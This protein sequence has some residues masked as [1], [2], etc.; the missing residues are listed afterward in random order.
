M[1]MRIY[2]RNQGGWLAAV[3]LLLMGL[4]A[5]DR[6]NSSVSPKPN[7]KPPVTQP[8]GIDP[9]ADCLVS[10]DSVCGDREVCLKPCRK[11][12]HQGLYAYGPAACIAECGSS[13]GENVTCL[14]PCFSACGGAPPPSVAADA[15]HT[16]I[17]SGPPNPSYQTEA[18][19]AFH[20]SQPDCTFACRLNA[21][22][23]SHCSSPVVIR[24]LADGTH[25][26]YV[27][28]FVGE[29]F[30]PDPAVWRWTIDTFVPVTPPP[31]PEPVWKIVP[32][33][34]T[35]CFD[36]AEV[37]PC[38]AVG[39]VFYGQDAQYAAAVSAYVVHADTVVDPVTGLEWQRRDDGVQREWQQAV[40]HCAELV[41]DEKADWRLP[42]TNEL[43]G[44]I[45]F[46]RASPAI[47]SQVFPETK[48]AMYWAS[49]GNDGTA[50]SVLFS[51]GYVFSMGK[52]AGIIYVR[53][54]RGG[55]LP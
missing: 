48:S 47:D 29:L 49:D 40:N 37:I 42:G 5:C 17:D 51:Y 23:W 18:D 33:G 27:R 35:R 14:D 39:E 54:V 52:E 26:F 7:E 16:F 4:S 8:S 21:G 36:D 11:T 53:C 50:W 38:P 22:A 55:A 31:P 24:S 46:G 3:L 28:A 43:L 44:I 19:F 1:N 25:T 6:N 13:C 32:S 45:D 2:E 12:C 10:C 30:D 20:C 34:Q 9:V 15:P 41:L